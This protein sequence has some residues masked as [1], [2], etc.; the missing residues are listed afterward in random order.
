MSDWEEFK[1]EHYGQKYSITYEQGMIDFAP[2]S[3]DDVRGGSFRSYDEY[4]D[5]QRNS[6]GHA[7]RYFELAYYAP[8]MDM[9]FRG[10]IDRVDAEK[11]KIVFKRIAI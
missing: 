7:R 5:V 10:T 1:K 9:H 2:E 6:C 11:A 8:A 4:L 3:M